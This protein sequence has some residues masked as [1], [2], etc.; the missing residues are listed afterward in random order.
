MP[1]VPIQDT[2]TQVP[3]SQP[4]VRLNAPEYQDFGNQQTMQAGR[5]LSSAGAE[6]GKLAVDAQNEANQLRV[7]DAMNQAVATR[8][9]LTYDKKE[10]FT[11]LKGE[12]ALK[13]GEDGQGIDQKYGERF[14]TTI[15]D[16]SAKLGNEAQ[17]KIFNANVGSVRNQFSATLQSHIMQEQQ[18]YDAGVRASTI[19]LAQNAGVQEWDNQESVAKAR[20]AI[21]AAIGGDKS[22]S[23]EQKAAATL[24][25]LSPMHAGVM[26]TAIEKGNFDYAKEYLTNF[27]KELTAESKVRLQTALDVGERRVKIQSFG[28]ELMT[29]G[30][31]LEEA[32]AK[33]RDKFDGKDEDEAV[34]EVKERYGEKEIIQTREVKELGKGAWSQVMSTGRLSSTMVA[35]LTIKAPEEL[36]QIRDWQDQKRRQAKAEAEGGSAE[37]SGLFAELLLQAAEKPEKFADRDQVDLAKYQPYLAKG[38]FEHLV[39]VQAGLIKDGAKKGSE[40]KMMSTTMKLIDSE[41]K[42]IG[43]D[44]TPKEGSKQAEEY[45]KF[46]DTLLSALMEEK[47]KKGGD[48]LTEEDMKK[49]GMRMVR[50]G[51]EQDAPWYRFTKQM[52]GYKIESDPELKGNFVAKKY[53]DIP[54]DTRQALLDTY[55]KK[56]PGVKL[57]RG[58]YGD[59]KTFVPDDIQ[60][61]IEKAYTQ[62]IND[63]TFK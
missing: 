50:T 15:S 32:L 56:N 11:A 42:R 19:E 40:V 37:K 25:S 27:G 23:E 49:I 18:H 59:R 16:I 22:L 20:G 26:A 31:K 8:M 21:V 36:R 17:R 12:Q 53:G 13:P 34:R 46:R 39:Q 62:G 30:L 58:I 51:I 35:D 52:P 28:D 10:G 54:A 9:R 44:T 3:G 48:S 14:D 24:K 4:N 5:A 1:V 43:I 47:A 7:N 57:T 2:F 55:M 60:K 6:L 45:S 38:A 29:Q 41:V 63:G 61:Q 33:A